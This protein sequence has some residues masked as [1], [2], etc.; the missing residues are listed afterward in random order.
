[1]ITVSHKFL[2]RNRRLLGASA[3]VSAISIVEDP[4]D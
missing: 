2:L 4:I 3:I 1:M